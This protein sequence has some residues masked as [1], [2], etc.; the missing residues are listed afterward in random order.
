MGKP[1]ILIA[2]MHRSGT[3]MVAELLYR[4]GLALGAEDQLFLPA[5]EDNPAG[6]WEIS[7]VLR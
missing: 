7:T 6:Y 5:N 4:C 3:S 2:G 1:P